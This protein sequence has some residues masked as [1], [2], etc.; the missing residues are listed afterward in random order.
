[1]LKNLK[2]I[3]IF[4]YCENCELFSL[5]YLNS[6][7]RTNYRFIQ[8]S[9]TIPIMKFIFSLLSLNLFVLLAHSAAINDNNQNDPII[10]NKECKYEKEPWSECDP[11]TGLQKRTLKLKVNL[12][13]SQCE[14]IKEFTR[15]CKKACRYTKGVWSECVNSEKTRV[16]TLK[17]TGISDCEPTR[18]TKKRCKQPSNCRYNKTEWS[19]CENDQKTKTLTLE[20]GDPSE[21]EEKKTITKQCNQNK[22][23]KSGR[24]KKTK[25][26]RNDNKKQELQ[27]PSNED[28]KEPA[29]EELKEQS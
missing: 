17:S 28:A 3:K 5:K 15:Q 20:S 8:N 16:D 29:N 22:K 4:E 25:K 9:S 10:R 6:S 19:A 27:A 2:L 1:M 13:N 21:C 26:D 11:S 24:R 18:T 14:P 12:Q 23:N 7:K